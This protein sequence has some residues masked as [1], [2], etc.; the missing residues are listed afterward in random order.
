MK[1]KEKQFQTK[2]LCHKTITFFLKGQGGGGFIPGVHGGGGGGG[3]GFLPGY[4]C[5]HTTWT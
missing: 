5:K 2:Y 3:G 1:K 4:G